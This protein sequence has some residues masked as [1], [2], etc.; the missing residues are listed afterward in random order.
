VGVAPHHIFLLE[1]SVERMY[2]IAAYHDSCLKKRQVYPFIKYFLVK[3]NESDFLSEMN[4][5][6]ESLKRFKGLQV[7]V[8]IGIEPPFPNL[9][10]VFVLFKRETKM[11]RSI[12]ISLER[13]SKKLLKSFVLS[14]SSNYTSI[15]KP[16]DFDSLRLATVNPTPPPRKMRSGK[17]KGKEKEEGDRRKEGGGTGVLEEVLP[18]R[19]LD[20]FSV[21]TSLCEGS[22]G[23]VSE[24]DFLPG[25][26]LRVAEPLLEMLGAGSYA[27]DPDDFCGVVVPLLNT[28][29][30]SFVPFTRHFDCLRFFQKIEPLLPDLHPDNLGLL[31]A[32]KLKS[33][34]NECGMPDTVLSYLTERKNGKK[35]QRVFET[36]QLLVVHNNMDIG[37]V[38][39]ERRCRCVVRALGPGD[40][41]VASCTGCI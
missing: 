1:A 13:S 22:G 19:S 3:G 36:S 38:D 8:S 17:E 41:E 29:D 33:I 39:M 23:S 35:A 25:S 24:E 21:V 20:I 4:M 30:S 15:Q 16:S 31:M 2:H 18:E 26:V 11:I 9:S 6:L 10:E 12:I 27:L 28:P 32:L 34:A 14:P 40:Q 7:V 5:L 37:A